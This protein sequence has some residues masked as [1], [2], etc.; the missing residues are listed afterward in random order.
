VS[1]RRR[2]STGVLF[3]TLALLV[4]IGIGPVSREQILAAYVLLLAAI[5]LAAL[6]RI[7][8]SAAELPPPSEFE[9]ALRSPADEPMRPPELIRIEREI[10]LGMSS[11]WYL[12]KRLAPILRDAAAAR[13][14]DFER[15]PDAARAL[16]GDELW[17]L[18]RPG[19]QEPDH[20]ARSPLGFAELRSAV[21]RLERL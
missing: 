20:T 7:L 9:H 12:H 19:K 4:A 16:L 11:R 17:E 18:I 13:G 5:A 6:T 8:R 10:R 21:D 2:I 15:R 1:E 14:V 3:A